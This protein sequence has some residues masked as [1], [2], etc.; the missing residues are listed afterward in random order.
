MPAYNNYKQDDELNLNSL[1]VGVH[2]RATKAVLLSS[3]T[4]FREQASSH[5]VKG[6]HSTLGRK[7][8]LIDSELCISHMATKVHNTCVSCEL[9]G[10]RHV[11]TEEH[12]AHIVTGMPTFSRTTVSPT[13]TETQTFTDDDSRAPKKLNSFHSLRVSTALKKLI[14]P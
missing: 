10:A 13:V 3:S 1:G 5:M 2:N 4:S 12:N 6:A 9:Y 11:A 8:F 7:I 14:S